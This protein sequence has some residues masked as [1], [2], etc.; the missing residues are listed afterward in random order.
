MN[1]EID[2]NA[3]K[4][5]NASSA[6]SLNTVLDLT[7]LHAIKTDLDGNILYL[8]KYIQEDPK[9]SKVKNMKNISELIDLK[10][11]P[12]FLIKDHKDLSVLLHNKI[13]SIVNT[14][15]VPREANGSCFTREANEVTSRLN[16]G[17]PASHF[18]HEA[19]NSE[20]LIFIE[21]T[22]KCFE[23]KNIF[24]ANLAHEIR[25]YLNIMISVMSIV[26]DTTLNDEQME[27]FE[28]LKEASGNMMNVVDNMLDYAKLEAGELKL[29]KD[30][31]YFRGCIE[32]T[33]STTC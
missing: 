30:S 28:M 2:A 32:V 22:A 20:I 13:D 21:S 25:K 5:K 11:Y 19:T 10:I 12:D 15:H 4:F 8:N 24:L 3:V 7:P 6:W 16:D 18:V 17:C 29:K 1:I 23:I 9:M 26:Q 27:Y 31:F 14:V 33:N